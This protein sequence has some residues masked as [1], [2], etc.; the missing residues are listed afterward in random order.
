M[1]YILLVVDKHNEEVTAEPPRV[2]NGSECKHRREKEKK[3]IPTH[4][5]IPSVYLPLTPT[6]AQL[7]SERCT[8]MY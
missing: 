3:Y 8:R 4:L 5:V 6:G 7:Y 2:H 1:E